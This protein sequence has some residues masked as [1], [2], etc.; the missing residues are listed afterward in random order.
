MEYKISFKLDFRRNPYPGKFIV[1]EGI[2]GCGKTTQTAIVVE[3]LKAQG[4]DAIYTKEPTDGPIGRFIRQTLRGVLDIS[5][6][7][8]QYLLAADR[9][10]HAQEIEKHLKEGKT[11]VSDRYFWSAVAYGM[12]DRQGTKYEDNGHVLLAIQGILSMYSQFIMPDITFYLQTSVDTALS[13]LAKMTKEK[14]LYETREKLE[15]IY[16]G[17]EWLVSQFPK[18]I[19][20]VDGEKTV[21]EVTGE[22]LNKINK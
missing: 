16:Q 19:T 5:P 20:V 10:L 13:R 14:E 22:I 8:I 17:Y 2:D 11:L 3:K 6:L 21:G 7:A 4:A 15:K 12:A 18:E 9:V 1:I